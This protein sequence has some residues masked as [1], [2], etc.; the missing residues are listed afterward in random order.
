MTEKTENG[1]QSR[2]RNGKEKIAEKIK[3]GIGIEGGR[4]LITPTWSEKFLASSPLRFSKSS[5]ARSLDL[6][7]CL[8][9]KTMSQTSIEKSEESLRH[10]GEYQ[11]KRNLLKKE[12]G[13]KNTKQGLATSS[14]SCPKPE[15]EKKGNE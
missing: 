3:K 14:K 1:K 12:E 7:N 2:E 6:F 13:R 10:L 9:H 4:K 11:N 15:F 8:Q 5:S